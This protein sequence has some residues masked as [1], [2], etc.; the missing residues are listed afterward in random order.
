MAASQNAVQLITLI[1]E[2]D[3]DAAKA[4]NPL[5]QTPFLFAIMH[6]Q[7][8]AAAKLVHGVADYSRKDIFGCSAADYLGRM[9][10]DNRL[11][12]HRLKEKMAGR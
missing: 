6:G 12:I 1:L 11:I 9:G 2:M 4:L 3:P 5:Q 8:E 7:L 10:R